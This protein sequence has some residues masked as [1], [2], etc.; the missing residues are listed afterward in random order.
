M[1]LPRVLSHGVDMFTPQAA[2]DSRG[3]LILQQHTVLV[4]GSQA[5]KTQVVNEHTS[6]VSSYSSLQLSTAASHDLQENE[7]T[8][9]TIHHGQALTVINTFPKC[10]AGQF[11]GTN[12][13]RQT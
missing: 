4:A 3:E 13:L 8:T 12:I 7:N 6:L 1:R 11:A 10:V 9:T 2:T 5:C